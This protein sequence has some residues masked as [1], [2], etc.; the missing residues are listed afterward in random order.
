MNVSRVDFDGNFYEVSGHWET[1]RGRVD[2]R[3]KLDREGNVVG[4]SLSP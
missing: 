3:V 2:F 4:W 1:D